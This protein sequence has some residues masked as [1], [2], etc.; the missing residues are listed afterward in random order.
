[1]E[2]INYFLRVD[3]S[4][5]LAEGLCIKHKNKESPLAF[6]VGVDGIWVSG[7]GTSYIQ[8]GMPISYTLD[9]CARY[10]F[11]PSLLGIVL[12]VMKCGMDCSKAFQLVQISLDEMIVDKPNNWCKVLSL[13]DKYKRRY[14]ND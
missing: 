7:I 1:M 5:G 8:E 4:K 12:D 3:L 2:E 9:E 11:I 14:T 13:F 10:M 6:F